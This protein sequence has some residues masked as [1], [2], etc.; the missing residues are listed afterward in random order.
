[1][2][3]PFPSPSLSAVA[4]GLQHT[5][6]VKQDG[7]LWAAGRNKKKGQ[8]GDGST[9]NKRSFAKV[10]SSDVKAV[11]AGWWH[12]MV[13]K[14]DDSVWATGDGGYGQLGDGSTTDKRSFV[15]V[16][17]TTSATT[18]ATPTTSCKAWCASNGRPWTMKC[19]WS[20][21]AGCS[22]CS[23]TTTG[24]TRNIGSCKSWCASNVQKWTTKCTWSNYCAGCSPCSGSCMA[25]YSLSR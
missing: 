16:I 6:V 1:M 14:Q 25:N 11:S 21:C 19:T 12:T 7:S 20:S 15:Q 24:T 5:M 22:S 10:I 13:V 23:G 2:P 3:S 17:S 4:A 8:L 9:T 18:I